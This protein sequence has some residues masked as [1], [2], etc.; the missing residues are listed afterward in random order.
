MSV[1][2]SSEWVAQVA[3]SMASRPAAPGVT[4]TVEVVITGG[5]GG[6]VRLPVRY[7]DGTPHWTGEP[8]DASE[9]AEPEVILTMPAAEA[10]AVLSGEREPSVGFM[11]G[12]I[13]TAGDPGLLLAWLRSTAT[14]EWQEWRATLD[15]VT[16]NMEASSR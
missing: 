15:H 1:W 8:A 14:P 6:E 7:D 2:L 3:T 10:R 9:R 12:R 4:G 11:R 16:S 13:K 5:P